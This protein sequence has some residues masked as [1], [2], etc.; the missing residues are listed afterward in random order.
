MLQEFLNTDNQEAYEQLVDQRKQEQM[1]QKLIEYTTVNGRANIKSQ[2]KTWEFCS[3][4]PNFA[5]KYEDLNHKIASTSKVLVDQF[6]ALTTTMDELSSYFD[7][8]GGLYENTDQDM[9]EI[10]K[11]ISALLSSWGDSYQGQSDILK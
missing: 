7:Q 4:I 11:S 8:L 9:L 5:K 1:P 6:K 2:T 10:N 3:E